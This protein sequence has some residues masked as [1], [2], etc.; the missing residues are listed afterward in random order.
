ME[1]ARPD[2]E[3]VQLSGD[4]VSLILQYRDRPYLFL[5]DTYRYYDLEGIGRHFE[6]EPYGPIYRLV[7]KNP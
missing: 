1:G 5:A 4:Q 6:I 3:L 2:V 7:E